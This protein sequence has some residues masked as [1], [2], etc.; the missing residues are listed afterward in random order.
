MFV[1]NCIGAGNHKFF[2]LMLFWTVCVSLS[3]RLR[4]LTAGRVG[5]RL[6]VA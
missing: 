4:L 3:L 2:L 6:P 1:G 5:R